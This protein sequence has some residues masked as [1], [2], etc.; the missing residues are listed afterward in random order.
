MIRIFVLC[1]IFLGVTATPR[2]QEKPLIVATASMWADMATRIGGDHFRVETVVP[3]GGDPHIHEPT[4]RDARIVAAADIILRNGLTFEGWLNE[5]IEN[6][7]TK[8]RNTLITTGITPI[9][10]QQYKNAT[11]PHAWMDAGNGLIY[12][13]NIYKALVAFLPS[14]EESLTKA[15]RAY[16]EELMATDRY[17]REKVA[18]IPEANRILITSHDAFQYFGRKYGVQLE[19][20]LGV[21]TDADIQTSDIR[22][23]NDV[24]QTTKVPAVFIESTI[25]PK[26]LEQI[27]SDNGVV[28]GGKLYA[29]SLGD[30]DSPAPTYIAMLRHNVDTIAEALSKQRIDSSGQE[31]GGLALYYT[32]GGLFILMLLGGLIVVFRSKR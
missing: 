25:N 8:A 13:E 31:Q 10:S 21:S 6:S 9:E 19:S 2:A 1:L 23:L 26:V 7:G 11:D 16:R 5:L 3:I 18:T 30:K 27:A 20:V 15:Y 12:I 24:L 4:P 28:V 32:L 22:H 14:E 17:I 29:D